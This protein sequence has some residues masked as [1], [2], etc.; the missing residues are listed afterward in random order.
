LRGGLDLFHYPGMPA[1]GR[2]QEFSVPATDIRASLD[3][4]TT[5]GFTELATG[6]VRTHHYAVVT[7]GRIAVG[8][9]E[10]YLEKTALSFVRPELA[11]Y[12]RSPEMAH[13][14]LLFQRLGIEDFHEVGFYGPDGELI[15]MMEARTFSQMLLDDVPPPVVGY[16][17]EISLPSPEPLKSLA[18]WQEAGFMVDGQTDN[19][20]TLIAPGVRLGLRASLAGGRPALQFMAADRDTLIANLEKE[21]IGSTPTNTGLRLTAPEGTPLLIDL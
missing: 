9:H 13:T 20:I 5:L 14:E 6:D 3:F 2:F 7:D 8:L 15:V 19:A 12:V 21:S 4:Y 10:G 18:F 16:L 11:A 1:L 17:T